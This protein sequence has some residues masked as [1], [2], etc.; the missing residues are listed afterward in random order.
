MN[1]VNS[2]VW[3]HSGNTLVS[4]TFKGKLMLMKSVLVNFV[5]ERAPLQ[6]V[7]IVQTEGTSKDDRITS[8]DGRLAF[9]RL[10]LLP[11]PPVIAQPA[12]KNALA[13]VGGSLDFGR[14]GNKVLHEVAERALVLSVGIDSEGLGRALLVRGAR[15]TSKLRLLAEPVVVAVV[16][17]GGTFLFLAEVLLVLGLVGSLLLFVAVMVT[18]LPVLVVVAVVV[19]FLG[20]F[21]GIK[22]FTVRVFLVLVVVMVRL[23]SSGIKLFAV[24]VLLLVVMRLLAMFRVKLFA[25]RVLPVLVVVRLLAMFGVKLFAVLMFGHMRVGCVGPAV[26]LSVFQVLGRVVGVELG[27]F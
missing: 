5:V 20:G 17:G 2:Q 26:V 1:Q 6:E 15:I 4:T 21:S 23:L 14:A 19:R 9:L 13:D 11:P 10:L 12:A 27:T 16:R 24:C 8:S 3:H 7:I 22:L 18:V 25:V